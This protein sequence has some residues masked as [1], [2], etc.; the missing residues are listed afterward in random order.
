MIKLFTELVGTIKGDLSTK[1]NRYNVGGSKLT[2]T[3]AI[4]EKLK[5]D[6]TAMQPVIE[7]AKKD[8]AELIVQVDKDQEIATA[9][10]ADCAVDEKA[11]SEAAQEANAIKTDCQQE[12]DEA[13]P[14][15][16]SAI[17]SLDALD[18]KDIQ[19]IKSFAK[20]PPLVEV[21]LSAVCLLMGKKENWD[22]AKKLMN[23]NN[24]LP[25]LKSYDKDA[26]A[27]NTKLTAKLQK[28]IKRDDFVPDKVKSVSA[29]ATSLCLWVR[30]MDV[31]GRVSRSIEPKKARLA[32]AEAT[33]AKAEGQLASKKAELKAVQDKV[34]ALQAQLKRTQEKA[35]KLERDTEECKVKL[36]RAEKLLFGLGGEAVRWAAASEVLGNNLRFVIGNVVLAAGFIAYIGPF[37]AEFRREV[38]QRW[39]RRSQEVD[40][41]ADPDWNSVKV[42]VDPSE[43]RQWNIQGLPPD[44]LSIQNGLLATRGQRW[45]LMIDPQGQA[46][47]WIRNIGKERGNL[48]VI[49]LSDPT[50]LRS[51]E[52][53]IRM[54]QAVL[55]ENVEEVL[56][57]SLEPVLLK[58]VVKVGGLMTLRLG[59]EDVPYNQDFLFYITTKMANP[60]YLPE[61]C[62]KVTVINFTVTLAGLEDQLVTEVVA[63]ERPELAKMKS[64]LVVQ[65]AADK[66]EM[67]RL[68]Q[69]ILQLLS[70]SKGDLLADETLIN[71]LDQSKITGDGC[72]ERMKSAEESM[73]EI[74]EVTE[75]FK[76]V[77]LRASI[78]YFV[79]ADL[80]SI[81]PMYQYSLQ[82]FVSF[83]QQKLESSEQSE[84]VQYRIKILLN[85]F[86]KAIYTNICRGL[87]EV[88][89]LLFS[90][91]MTAQ[92][93]RNGTHTAFLNKK[94]I[95]AQEWSFFLRG[96]E[97]AKGVLD[98]PDVGD[99]PEWLPAAVWQKMNILEKLSDFEGI[100]AYSGICNGIKAG[101]IS[102]QWKSFSEDNQLHS[103]LLPGDWQKKL[104]S[105]QRLLVMK[106][107]RENL[108]FKCVRNF[109][110]QE[111]GEPFIV[112]PPFDLAS[113]YNDSQCTTPL[114]FVLSAGA[115][116]TEYLLKFAIEK[117][118][119]DK[120]H[121]ISLGQGQ[122]PKAEK[123]IANGHSDGDW[124][125]LQNCHLAA[126]WMPAL[127]RIQEAQDPD[128]IDTEYRLWLTSMPTAIFPVPV[129]QGGIKITNEPP[130]GLKAN[131]ARTFLD[132]SPEAYESCV[133]KPREFKKL[134][135][136][137][138]FFHGVILERR[139][140][141]PIGWNIGYEWMA[142]DL[143][144]SREQ[145]GMYLSSQP[146]VPWVTL[147]YIIAE[148]NY[149]GRVTDDKDVRLISAV[150]KRY[151]NDEI[152]QDNYKLTP[153]AE[154]FAPQEGSLEEV[155]EYIAGLP[156]DE[157]PQVFGLHPNALI[158]AQFNEAKTFLDAVVSV[159]PRLSSGGGRKK[160]EEIVAEMAVEFL[161]RVP[162]P[163]SKA[164]AHASTYEVTAE[165]GVVSLGVFHGQELDRF[166]AL[167]SVV[168]TTLWTLGQAIKGLVVM[169]NE[170]EDMYASF[171]TQRLPAKWTGCAYPCLKPLNSWVTDFIQRLDF[172][173]DWLV[174]GPPI[175]FWLPCFFFP[176]GFMT[177]SMQ[178]YA[179][180]TKI[181]IDTLLFWT[182][183]SDVEDPKFILGRP[184][185]GVNV[186]GLFL[187]GCTWDVAESTLIESHPGQLFAPVPII[188]LEPLFQEERLKREQGRYFCPLYKTSERRGTLSTTGHSTNFI[189]YL[190]LSAGARDDAHW[191]RRGVALLCMLDD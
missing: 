76:P 179:R 103:R 114:I 146:G 62:I 191:I 65:I 107:F 21:V 60:H 137:L 87:F 99:G 138:A 173:G 20:P 186:H 111:L 140:F 67:D 90:F 46:N 13:L 142:S 182:N 33:L 78:I 74:D 64:D 43:V 39:V 127:E 152:L 136:G 187:Q 189:T 101:D 162:E 35:A 12:L 143:Q 166:N 95:S 80:A 3:K 98:A 124:V 167:V 45:P 161:E 141:G 132:L 14:E 160:P 68:E 177:A 7:Q 180:K 158:T 54:G 23:D 73:K 125:C 185:N 104:S 37:T 133:E 40:L 52:N 22:E 48:G 51:L 34:A 188:L 29:A 175:S 25:S 17:K 19:E 2:E 66:T 120:L 31:Y 102:D 32:E 165:G 82:F 106:S 178:V 79:V 47:R 123:L 118:Y 86:T 72:K 122:G 81:D 53:G 49:K 139:K 131:L 27:A 156:M 172:I 75:T 110:A 129:L 121:I 134:L 38:V 116:P 112:S 181:P 119:Q 5:A 91:L 93:L 83:F 28:Y 105:F 163:K 16:Y 59:T 56:D 190:H 57:P 61:I 30:A 157:D 126:S 159:Q 170:M 94:S 50:F 100:G 144:V 55:L 155:R 77:A 135:F 148:V 10:A 171:L 36:G 174:N 92:I 149:G 8:T 128:K 58:Q 88:H 184:E 4:V 1:L 41:N 26:L 96:L 150:L 42:L 6:L 85:D 71:T 115:D 70:D 151:F 113:A 15:F 168:R 24:F 147:N 109:V 169:S 130:K 145:L 69:L 18:K 108:F 153:L 11:A 154:Y 63:H 9:K 176:Q 89:K 84:D 183:V 164:T 117:E 44:D 97:A